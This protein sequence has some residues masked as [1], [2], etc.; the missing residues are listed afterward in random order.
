MEHLLEQFLMG[1]MRLPFFDAG[2]LELDRD[3]PKSDLLALMMLQR[4]GEATM[5][6]LAADLGAPLSTATGIGARLEKRKLIERERQSRDRRVI[7]LRLTP[8][9]Q[10]L[11]GRAR[12]QIGSILGRIQAVLTPEEIQQLMGLVQKVIAGLQ[13]A[14]PQP[15]QP[16]PAE[17]GARRIPIEE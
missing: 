1:S 12:E 13:A 11:A 5:S 3:L 8:A 6:E 10:E 7:L 2:V 16:A 17:G 15:P 4:R 14:E 9:G